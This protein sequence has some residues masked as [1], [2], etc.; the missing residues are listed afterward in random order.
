MSNVRQMVSQA[1]QWAK[2]ISQ[3]LLFK[4]SYHLYQTT[5]AS[6]NHAIETNRRKV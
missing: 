5:A 4:R 6:S 1:N 2:M 3:A